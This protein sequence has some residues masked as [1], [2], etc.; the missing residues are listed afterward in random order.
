MTVTKLQIC[1]I[2]YRACR[3]AVGSL[4]NGLRAMSDRRLLGAIVRHLIEQNYVEQRLMCAY[5]VFEISF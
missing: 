1:S 3:R 5:A 4:F 2:S